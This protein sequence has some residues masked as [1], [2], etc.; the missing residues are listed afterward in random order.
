MPDITIDRL[1]LHLS[2]L[3]EGDGQRLARLIADGLANACLPEGAESRASVKAAANTSQGGNMQALSDR[4]V[5]DVLRQL[6]S[7]V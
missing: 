6:Q 4:L 1:T 5:A 7:S 3:S 2:G